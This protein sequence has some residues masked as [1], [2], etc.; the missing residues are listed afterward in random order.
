MHPSASFREVSRPIR[1]VLAVIT[2]C[3]VIKYDG[4]W[5]PYHREVGPIE[6]ID[7]SFVEK[8]IGRFRDQDKDWAIIEREGEFARIILADDEELEQEASAALLEHRG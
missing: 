3:K 2:P 7:V 8:L 5:T 4:L 6:I 1:L